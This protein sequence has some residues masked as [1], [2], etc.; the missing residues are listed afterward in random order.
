MDDVIPGTKA[1][2]EQTND[3]IPGYSLRADSLHAR[4]KGMVLGF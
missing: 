4:A 3:V 2:T 1:Q